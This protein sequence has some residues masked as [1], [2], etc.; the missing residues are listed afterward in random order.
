MEIYFTGHFR[1]NGTESYDLPLCGYSL[2]ERVKKLFPQARLY[3][4]EKRGVNGEDILGISLK[5]LSDYAFAC[6]RLQADILL[7]LMRR[8]VLI[9][10]PDSVTVEEGAEIESDV[11]IARGSYIERET[12]VCSGSRIG[13]YAYLKRGVKVGHGCCVGA[14]TEI[15]NVTM[16]DGSNIGSSVHVC[17]CDNLQ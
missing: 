14:F 9:E 13:P 16:T 17:K 5:N 12:K 6:K 7:S 3:F 8:G 10:D 1:F 4:N 11:Y 15:E 2:A